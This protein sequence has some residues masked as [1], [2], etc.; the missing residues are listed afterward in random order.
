[1]VKTQDV[2]VHQV[3]NDGSTNKYIE[4]YKMFCYVFGKHIDKK[5]QDDIA[6][7][8]YQADM[9]LTPGMFM[10]LALVTAGLSAGIIFILSVL[11]F[12]SS[13][14]PLVYISVLTFLTFGLTVSGFPFML[15][16]KVSNK[17]MNI[18]QEL[19]FTLGY[20]TI[21]ASSGSSPMDVIRKVAIEDYGDVSVE[22]G[23]VMY[24]VDVLGEDG[25]SA[26]NHL[27]RNT[28]SESLRAICIDLANAMQSGG[29]LRTYLEM[30]S[31]EL[32][33]MRRKMQQEFVDSLG[34]YG[35]GYLSG[36]V[37]SVV[38]VVLMIVVTSALGIDLGPFTAKQMFQFFVY[39]MLPFINIVFL[40]LLWMK[41]SR[42][43][44]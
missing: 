21:L 18:E 10:S 16:N 20:M 13:S 24:R 14:S 44:L 32:M 9:V 3:F 28:S 2:D 37:M 42:S 38:L 29:G 35:E 31:R 1:M 30:K 41:Y 7:S 26:M 34:V 12:R 17:N 39:F 11:L 43:T 5:P 36:V 19:P 15:Y 23:K 22:F 27:I 33:D 4:K 40:I 6:K 8:L 25:V